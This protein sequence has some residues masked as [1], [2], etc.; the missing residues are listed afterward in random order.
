LAPVLIGLGA[1]VL[2]A[3]L[4]VALI[5]LARHRRVAGKATLGG[6]RVE[7][8]VARAAAAAA[9]ASTAGLVSLLSGG[10]G[11]LA[12]VGAL[13][14]VFLLLGARTPDRLL[15]RW[16]L[17]AAWPLAALALVLLVASFPAAAYLGPGGGLFTFAISMALLIAAAARA[18]AGR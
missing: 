1:L 12:V 5:Q 8:P 14:V 6:P 2:A 17:N 3:G 4:S 18:S 7:G 16:R 15:A 11:W 10:F 9:G 13:G